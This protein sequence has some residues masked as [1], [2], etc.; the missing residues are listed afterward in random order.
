GALQTFILWINPL[1]TSVIFLSLAL[2]AK[3]D[4]KSYRS[5]LLIYF[6]MSLL[7]Y[8]NILYYREFAD[9]MTLST[10][11][12]NVSGDDSIL[13]GGVLGSILVMLRAWDVFFWIDF[14]GLAWLTR[15]VQRKNTEQAVNKKPFYKRYAF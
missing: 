7:L 14:V 6:L 5:M 1:A 9:F 13:T 11:L 8:A 15:R 3:N 2:Y 10:V 12:S 4:K